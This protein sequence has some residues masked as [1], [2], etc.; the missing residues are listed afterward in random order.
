MTYT[1]QNHKAGDTFP[2][3][4]FTL[5]NQDGPINLTGAVIEIIFNNGEYIPNFLGR[6]QIHVLTST[7][8]KV[9]IS[10][11]ASGEFNIK[12]QIISWEPR[13]YTGVL[14]V[15]FANGTIKT[16][17]DLTWTLK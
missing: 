12:Q 10:S 11:A 5:S 3:V 7:D 17:A 13:T 16:Y 1:L 14:R 4:L 6:N 9:V 2:G 8:G 15:K